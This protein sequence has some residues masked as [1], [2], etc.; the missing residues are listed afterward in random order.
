[1]PPGVGDHG[2]RLVAHLDNFS[3]AFL[4]FDFGGVETLQ[5][6]AMNRTGLDGGIQ[7][8]GQLDVDR[9]GLL[10]VSFSSVSS[11]LSGLPAIFYSFGSLSLMS[12]V[13]RYRLPLSPQFRQWAV[14]VTAVRLRSAILVGPDQLAVARAAIWSRFGETGV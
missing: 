5:L 2:D 10:A 9:V 12:A 11:R 6:A 1:V 3:H 4:A 13:I 7:Q 14:G 8:T